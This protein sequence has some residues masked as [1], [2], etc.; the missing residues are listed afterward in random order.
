MLVFPVVRTSEGGGGVRGDLLY[1]E[2]G[3]LLITAAEIPTASRKRGR[4]MPG[5]SAD[6]ARAALASRVALAGAPRVLLHAA[7][8]AGA[9][10]ADAF[11]VQLGRSIT[12]ALASV[13]TAAEAARAQLLQTRSAL[14]AAIDARCDELATKIDSTEASKAAAL[15]RELVAVDAALERWRA[16]TFAVRGAVSSL[17]DADVVLQHAALSTR[18]DGMETQL[19]ALPTAVV[20]PPFVGLVM[21]V[22]ALLSS[23]ASFGH[24]IAPLAITADDIR[25]DSAPSCVLPGDSLRLKLSLGVRHASQSTEELQVSLGR[26]AGCTLIESTLEGPGVE[27]QH[28]LATLSVGTTQRCLVV[29]LEVPSSA[30][31]ALRIVIGP[32][33]VAGQPV[34]APPLVLQVRRGVNP[35][36]LLKY[37]SRSWPTTPCISSGDGSIYCPPGQDSEVTVFDADGITLPGLPVASLGLTKFTWYSAFSQGDAPSLLLA[38]STISNAT[39]CLSRLVAIDPASRTVRWTTPS[40]SFNGICMGI[41]VLPSLGVVVARRGGFLSAHRLSDGSRVGT[42]GDPSETYFIAADPVTGALFGGDHTP[43]GM[44]SVCAWSCASEGAGILITL[45]G[46]VAAAG[47][48]QGVR[49]LAVVPPAPGKAISHLVVGTHCTSELLVLTLPGLALVHTHALEGM[50]V[51]GLAADPWGQAI[52]VCD[53][54]SKMLHVLAWPLPG[55]PPLQ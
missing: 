19:Q 21:D 24:I 1:R 36:L 37:D 14:H 20:E 35:P 32:L 5:I 46:P 31:R 25:V 13:S 3:I 47:T 33:S 26:L 16:D 6:V 34:S 41:A 39:P 54:Y 2:S 18:L 4:G 29:S 15:E 12:V 38:D 50:R 44:R 10:G 51:S 52:A 17:S 8:S 49:T 23:I 27:P 43:G 7:S 28:L 30:A 22:P 53:I 48:R 11:L 55:M 42:L 45:C 9:S 40:E